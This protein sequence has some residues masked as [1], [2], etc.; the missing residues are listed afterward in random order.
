MATK[1]ADQENINMSSKAKQCI[2]LLNI[3]GFAADLVSLLPATQDV[4]GLL[5]CPLVKAFTLLGGD[6]I[7]GACNFGIHNQILLHLKFLDPDFYRTYCTAQEAYSTLN[8]AA[9]A[10]TAAKSAIA[11]W[12][13]P[14]VP[15]KTMIPSSIIKLEE[16]Q[17]WL[18]S[19]VKV[20]PFLL[21]TVEQAASLVAEL[22]FVTLDL[23]EMG[24]D[25]TQL[26]ISQVSCSKIQQSPGFCQSPRSPRSPLR[27]PR[28]QRARK[29][30]S[31]AHF[32]PS[33]SSS[34]EAQISNLQASFNK[35]VHRV[36]RLGQMML[37]S[38]AVC[39][40]TISF[41]AIAY[42]ESLLP[43]LAKGMHK[44]LKSNLITR[45]FTL[46]FFVCGWTLG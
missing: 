26:Q 18:A 25:D 20:V 1:M 28:R 35:L 12:K 33:L 17:Q 30:E 32:S 15:N 19:M 9:K 46:S 23:L 6:A 31:S 16:G 14:I 44:S 40:S 5:P 8:G 10:L 37:T 43:L 13:N 22:M 11:G 41:L 2:P 29:Q 7:L 34:S 42:K 3:L 21:Y 36:I 45:S 27:S 4:A 39:S 24:A 38:K